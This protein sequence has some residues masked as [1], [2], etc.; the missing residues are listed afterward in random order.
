MSIYNEVKL[1]NKNITE[2]ETVIFIARCF[3]ETGGVSQVPQ[4]WILHT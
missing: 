4:L 1:K 3:R 2:K